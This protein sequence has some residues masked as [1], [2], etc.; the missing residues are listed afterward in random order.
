MKTMKTLPQKNNIHF[1]FMA[2][3][4]RQDVAV[5]NDFSGKF[6]VD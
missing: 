6:C 1:A 3:P 2:K 4:L 5:S